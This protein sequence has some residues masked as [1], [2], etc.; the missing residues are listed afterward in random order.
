[1][2]K[3]KH[4]RRLEEREKIQS[5]VASPTSVAAMANLDSQLW[6][7]KHAPHSF[8]HLLSNE[9]CNRE[10]VR[11]LR[12]WDPYVFGRPPPKRPTYFKARMDTDEVPEAAVANPRDKRPDE[13]SRVILLS[14]PP[15]VG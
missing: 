8:S 6:V 10:V 15:G 5:E 12:E 11:A 7:D 4:S 3:V 14:G 9:R 2:N 13:T 1:M